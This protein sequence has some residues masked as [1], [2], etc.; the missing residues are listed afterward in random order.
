MEVI[1]IFSQDLIYDSNM[2][3]LTLK[4][5]LS[6]LRAT[7]HNNGKINSEL[8]RRIGTASKDFKI[9]QSV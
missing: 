3:L 2:K 4:N 1:N 7:I 8:N 6:Y 9:L 5:S